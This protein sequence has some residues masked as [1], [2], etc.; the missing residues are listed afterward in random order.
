MYVRKK[1]PRPVSQGKD[2]SSE[3]IVLFQK[4]TLWF[5]MIRKKTV[6]GFLQTYIVVFVVSLDRFIIIVCLINNECNVAH[7]SVR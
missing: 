3:R 5:P 2:S 1:N 7:F 4:E 6:D